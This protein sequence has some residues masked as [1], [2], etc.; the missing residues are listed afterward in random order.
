MAKMTKIKA[1][2]GRARGQ[3]RRR[4]LEVVRRVIE[5]LTG[6]P[7]TFDMAKQAA[8]KNWDGRFRF[9]RKEREE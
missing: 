7:C 4:A 5:K 6:H 3:K 2:Q 9:P 8:R 1:Y